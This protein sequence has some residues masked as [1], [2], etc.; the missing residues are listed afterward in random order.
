MGELGLRWHA[1]VMHAE[2]KIS[3]KSN[4]TAQP[5]YSVPRRVVGD[6]LIDQHTFIRVH[7]HPK[8]FPV[9]SSCDWKVCHGQQPLMVV[10]STSGSSTMQIAS[11]SSIDQLR[12][13]VPITTLLADC[14]EAMWICEGPHPVQW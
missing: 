3:L 5:A 9:A 1:N 4:A 7:C 11:L 12:L 14:I 13:D 2:I 6:K 8:R 10:I